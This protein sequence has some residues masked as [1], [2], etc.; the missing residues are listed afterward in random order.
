MASARA[1]CAALTLK[2]NN[3]AKKMSILYIRNVPL[4]PFLSR[5]YMRFYLFL[6]EQETKKKKSLFSKAFICL[7]MDPVGRNIDFDLA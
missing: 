7:E 6:C 3:S 5:H 2:H 4:M 1:L